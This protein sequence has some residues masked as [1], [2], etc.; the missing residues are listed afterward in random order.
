MFE[1]VHLQDRLFDRHRADGVGLGADRELG[2]LLVVGAV[3]EIGGRRER[4]LA[5]PLLK[6][7]L[8]PSDLPFEGVDGFIEGGAERVRALF[9]A[10]ERV[11]HTDRDL[12][13]LCVATDLEGHVR[14]H[15][16]GK[17]LVQSRQF[18]LRQ[19]PEIVA[20][21]HLSSA[22]NDFHPLFHPFDF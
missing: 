7:G 17:V 2:F 19:F 12:D 5:D 11:P 4:P 10:E 1:Q 22:A 20:Y 3:G 9:G 15:V 13:D 21:A 18:L 6:P 8:V 14:R 16:V